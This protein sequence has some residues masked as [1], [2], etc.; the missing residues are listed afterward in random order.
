[1]KEK[2]I[3]FRYVPASK[4]PAGTTR[5]GFTIVELLITIAIIGLLISI[6][7]PALYKARQSG[8]LSA[9]RSNLSQLGLAM[10]VYAD[11]H[12]ELIPRGP[13]C[14]GPFDFACADVATNQLWIGAENEHHP[15]QPNG[16]GALIENYTRSTDIYFCPADDSNNL[17]EELP[18]IGSD[19]DAYGSYTYRQLDQLPARNRGKLSNLGTNLVG[20]VPVPVEALAL[21]TNSLG[22]GPLR[23][24]NHGAKKVNV[25]YRDRSVQT[26]ANKLGTFSIL[27]ETFASPEKIFTRL[28]QILVNADYGY[29]QDPDSAP[30]IETEEDP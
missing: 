18:R 23:H 6:A 8:K 30:Q 9:C 5:R 27:P 3:R 25:L 29:R 12:N 13:V 10:I 7:L 4:G 16:L 14:T 1:M 15:K 22:P 20:D 28:D 24:T 19:L 26:F 2:T 21:D 17:E 11:Q